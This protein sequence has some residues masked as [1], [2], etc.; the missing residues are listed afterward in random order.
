MFYCVTAWPSPLGQVGTGEMGMWSVRFL[1]E[2]HHQPVPSWC[3]RSWERERL[4]HFPLFSC[5]KLSGHRDRRRDV[6]FWRGS[7]VPFLSGLGYIP[8]WRERV[9]N[10]LGGHGFSL[11]VPNESKR[12][13][14]TF[15][16]LTTFLSPFS[17][18]EPPQVC[19][20]ESTQ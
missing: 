10:F 5:P 19:G 18:G 13:T 11:C 17:P 20:L 16:R 14:V 9:K 15:S 2:R 7:P 1:R 12:L 3:P 8:T 6:S 4:T